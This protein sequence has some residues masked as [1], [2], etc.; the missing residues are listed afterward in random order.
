MAAR[1]SPRQPNIVLITSD[2]QRYDTLGCTGCLVAQTPNLDALAARGT[3]FH[4]HF[5]TNPVCSP[6]RGSFM[7]GLYPNESGL[8]AN[9]CALPEDRPT[10]ASTLRGA[11]YQTAHVG[12]LHLV[13]ILN[14]VAPH[15]AYG[16]D[17]HE[18]GEGDQ[19]YV[20]DDHWNDL[21]T[22]DPMAYVDF[23]HEAYEHGHAK[24]YTSKLPE[25][26][27]HSSWVTRR[28]L[29]WLEKTRDARR[30]FFLN[31]GYFDPHHAFNPIEPW[32]SRFADVDVPEP[33]HDPLVIHERPACYRG[34][35]A[36][37]RFALK[38][39]DARRA[40]LRAYH[41]MISH[42]DHCVGQLLAGLKRHDLLDNTVVVFTSDHGEM[43]G[44]HG[45]L[46][47]G[48]FFLDDLMRVPLIVAAP[49]AEPAESDR[50][51]SMID[52]MRT[53]TEWAGCH[54]PSPHG[55][56]LQSLDNRLLPEDSHEAVFAQWENPAV[57]SPDRSIR[58]VR[59]DR[60][61][62]VTYADPDVGELYDLHE[63]P[64]ETRNRFGDPDCRDTRNDLTNRIN[65]CLHHARPETPAIIGW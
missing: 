35:Y 6:S 56:P 62:L 58:M 23:M 41:A 14:R 10:L 28:S 9:G 61:K 57:D 21:R 13:P 39:A 1:P 50:L 29:D 12:K 8:W 42:L 25:S 32:A 34:N 16:F 55:K 65:S 48:P 63:D 5:V 30:P 43:L 26:L 33:F 54:C 27:H 52:L 24:G 53:F 31:V 22:T 17:T 7:T 38:D 4:Q 37:G 18:V 46:H 3:L 44:H 40:V 49:G 15:P 19:M 51:T 47:K 11:G 20:H 2:Q 36:F 60:H 64:R 59:T 45:M